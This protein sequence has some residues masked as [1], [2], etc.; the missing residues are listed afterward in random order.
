MTLKSLL[1][2]GSER[3]VA[4]APSNPG[5]TAIVLMKIKNS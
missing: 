1:L 2:V 3:N 4:R 5:R